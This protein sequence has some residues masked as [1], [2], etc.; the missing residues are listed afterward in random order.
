MLEDEARH[1][2]VKRVICVRQS[3]TWNYYP[4]VVQER[5]RQHNAIYI[6]TLKV[7]TS[8]LQVEN[9][10]SILD[11]VVGYMLAAAGTKIKYVVGLAQDCVD[12]RIECDTSV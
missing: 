2:Y 6:A 7:R 4:R 12:L 9:A 8:T 1:D 11:N 5:I 3:F 10:A